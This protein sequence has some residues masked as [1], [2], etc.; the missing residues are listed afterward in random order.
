[1]KMENDDISELMK[2]LADNPRIQKM[3]EYIQHGNTTTYSHVFR[4]ARFAARLDRFFPGEKRSDELIIAAILHDYYLYDWHNH[5]DHLH[6]F[7]HPYIAADNAIKDFHVSKNVADAIKSH[8]WPL[9]I[10]EV[11][12]SRNA[13]ILTISDKIVSAEET[14]IRK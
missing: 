11:P 8:M 4:V 2:E 12:K 6:G 13:W 3:K 9:N 5:G 14:V 7:H 10:L 1:M